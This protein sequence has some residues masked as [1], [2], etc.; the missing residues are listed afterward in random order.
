[1]GMNKSKFLEINPWP[2]F[3]DIAF[4]IRDDDVS[5]FTPPSR[6]EM[7]YKNIWGAGFKVSFAV[8]PNQK[9]VNKLNVPPAFRNN[10]QWF[11]VNENSCLTK[12]LRTKIASGSIEILQHGFSHTDMINLPD[13]YFDFKR[14]NISYKQNPAFNPLRT[15]EFINL[16]EVDTIKRVTE[17]KLLL[18]QCFDTAIETF[19]APQ[20]LLTKSLWIAIWRNK[21]NYCGGLGGNILNIIPLDHINYSNLLRTYINEFFNRTKNMDDNKHLFGSDII[22]IPATFRHYWNR[23]ID[24][25]MSEYWF[26]QFKLIWEERERNRSHF[27][28]LTHYWEYFYDWDEEITQAEQYKYLTKIIDFINKKNVWKCKL[29]HLIKWISARNDL[30]IKED[31]NIISIISPKTDMNGVSVFLNNCEIMN[32]PDDR[33]KFYDGD[34]LIFNLEKGIRATFAKRG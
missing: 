5:F 22:M 1:M 16:N 34:R 28:L 2:F 31:K 33:I 18:E 11:S 9:A 14:G 8:I 4:S 10:D 30:I 25:G 29:G 27:I 13:P 12:Y 15:S 26:N 20:E 24:N 21:Q 7:I 19:V 3:H 17:G 6:L 32:I 23:F